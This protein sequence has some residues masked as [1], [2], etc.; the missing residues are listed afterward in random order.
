VLS[1]KTIDWDL[2]RQQCDQI[3]KYTTTLRLGTPEAEQGL[4]R[5]THGGP[6]RPT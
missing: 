1:A 4:R 6:E 3:V 2:V 5:F